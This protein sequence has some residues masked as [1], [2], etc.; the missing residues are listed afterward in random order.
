MKWINCLLLD[1]SNTVKFVF[2][3]VGT[4]GGIALVVSF[5]W[6]F[7]RRKKSSPPLPHGKYRKIDEREC[8]SW[9]MSSS[10]VLKF[11]KIARAVRR[12]QFENF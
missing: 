1:P 8:I 4:M 7:L 10:D 9:F 2:I 11:L 12:E 5:L 6:F 3:V